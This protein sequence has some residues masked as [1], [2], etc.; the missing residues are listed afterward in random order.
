MIFIK[1]PFNMQDKFFYK[2]ICLCGLFCLFSI[3]R[4]QSQYYI[5]YPYFIDSFDDSTKIILNKIPCSVD[6]RF[7]AETIRFF[8]DMCQFMELHPGYKCN[9][10]LYDF[11]QTSFEKR[12]AWTKLQASKLQCFLISSD[13]LCDFSFINEIIPN[14]QENPVFEKLN[15]ADP[16][17]N[18]SKQDWAFL[19][20]SIILELLR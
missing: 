15:Y 16:T 5:G 7:N 19:K 14:G 10:Y 2:T 6:G 8:M 1:Q 18:I 9:I 12:L 20:Q 4:V 3:G 11:E 17:N 13:T